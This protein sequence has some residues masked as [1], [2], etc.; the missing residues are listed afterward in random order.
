M[1]TRPEKRQVTRDGNTF[2]QTFHVSDGDD[3]NS[4]AR[5]NAAAAAAGLSPPTPMPEPVPVEG[6]PI[7]LYQ[8][9]LHRYDAVVV[10]VNDGTTQIVT[11]PTSEYIVRVDDEALADEAGEPIWLDDY[12]TESAPKTGGKKAPL[13]ATMPEGRAVQI[14]QS[15]SMAYPAVIGETSEDG[16]VAVI[17]DY[18]NAVAANVDYEEVR[19]VDGEVID[20]G[21]YD[22]TPAALVSVVDKN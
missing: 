20:V 11:D 6:D 1:T 8:T 16:E 2:E 15:V 3:A 13:A 9:R 19:D 17:V 4:E 18:Q 21:E 5:G 7:R 14:Y 22:T 12:D 10:G